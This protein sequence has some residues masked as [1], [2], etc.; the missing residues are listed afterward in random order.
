MLCVEDTTFSIEIQG[1]T[2]QK[3]EFNPITQVSKFSFV[4][5][6]NT[7]EVVC[8]YCGAKA[9]IKGYNTTTLKDIPFI[10]GFGLEYMLEH[11]RYFCPHCGKTFTEKLNIQHSGTRVTKRA[12]IWIKLLLKVGLSIA[13]VAKLTGIHWD[14]IRKIHLEFMENALTQRL[15]EW[16]LTGYKPQYLAVDEFALHRGHKYAT[17]V[18]DW[19]TGEI[20]WVGKGRSMTDFMLFFEETD[21]EFLSEVK[22]VAMDMN[23]AYN[24]L[25]EV[26]LPKAEIVYDRYHMQAEF[27]RTVLGSV[28][29]REAKE[30]KVKALELKELQKAET[31]AVKKA[32]LKAEI[33]SELAEYRQVKKARWLILTNNKNLEIPGQNMLQNILDAHTDLSVCYAFKEEMGRLYDL[34]DPEEARQGWLAWFSAAK[35]SGIYELEKYAINKEKR[36]EGLIAHAKYAISTGKLEGMNNKIKVAKRVAYG[37]RDDHYFFTLIQFN[38]LASHKIP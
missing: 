6:S 7:S 29:L 19:E 33:D 37:F 3:T 11:H 36:L 30:H 16:K 35:A 9:H 24:R 23:A 13:S 17:T 25:V 26:K 12:A 4:S 10:P 38:S 20:I 28:R 34:T 8:P 21:M 18:M 14:T 32:A 22:A 5:N 1:F 27:G 15:E 2:F 31:D